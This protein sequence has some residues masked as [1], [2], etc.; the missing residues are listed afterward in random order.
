[1]RP[2]TAARRPPAPTSA[3]DPLEEKR[4]QQ[5]QS[6]HDSNHT[7]DRSDIGIHDMISISSSTIRHGLSAAKSILSVLF[8]IFLPRTALRL[9]A[10]LFEA[11]GPQN[12]AYSTSMIL[13]AGP[14]R[15]RVIDRLRLAGGRYQ[16]RVAQD[17]QMLRQRRLTERHALIDL[18]DRQGAVE[19]S[20]TAP[21]A[22]G[23]WPAPLGRR[24][25]RSH[26][27]ALPPLPAAAGAV[28]F[29]TRRL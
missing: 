10:H 24:P 8:E 7:I 20:S 2:S 22:A 26:D 15:E 9:L 19:Q 11:A 3:A 13:S 17:A 5:G 28:F 23:R 25:P 18:A 29:T 21:G 27:P 4:T 6:Q 16:A 12:A 1:M 14:L